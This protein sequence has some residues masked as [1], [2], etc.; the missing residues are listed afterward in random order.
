MRPGIGQGKTAFNAAERKL[1][2][3]HSAAEAGSGSHNRQRDGDGL[4]QD[5][6]PSE[7]DRCVKPEA[8]A[9]IGD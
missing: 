7:L 8:A 3:R 9:V 2:A 1:T 5:G 6:K 4:S